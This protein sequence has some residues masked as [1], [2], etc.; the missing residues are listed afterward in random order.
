MKLINISWITNSVSN[1][2]SFFPCYLSSPNVGL[3]DPETYNPNA[4]GQMPVEGATR[5][6][7]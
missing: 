2:L 5:C 4:R 6:G 1:L 3:T 7:P